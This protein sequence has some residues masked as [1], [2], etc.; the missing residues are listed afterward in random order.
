MN[1]SVF[2]EEVESETIALRTLAELTGQGAIGVTTIH[3]VLCIRQ[4]VSVDAAYTS[5]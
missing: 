1:L 4:E 3:C 2:A 5:E